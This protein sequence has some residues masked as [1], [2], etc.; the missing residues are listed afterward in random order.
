MMLWLMVSSVAIAGWTPS[1]EAKPIARSTGDEPSKQAK[2]AGKKTAEKEKSAPAPA[3]KADD[4][5]K[6]EVGVVPI[7]ISAPHGGRFAIAD[8]PLRTGPGQ[9]RAPGKFVTATDT[10]TDRLALAIA[11]A[12]EKKLGKPHLVLA[13]FQRK[14]LDVNRPVSLGAEH[15][16][17]QDLHAKYYAHLDA[18]CKAVQQKFGR[19]LLLDIHG[20]SSVADTVFRGTNHGKTVTLL[21]QRF[22]EKAHNGPESFFGLLEKM[23]VKG[24]TE[25]NGKERAGFTGGFIVQTFGSHQAN[26]IDAI[27]LEFGSNYR[28]RDAIEQVASQI[29]DAIADYHQ[30]YLVDATKKQTPAT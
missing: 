22:G 21:K 29:A 2:P 8:V 11:A 18:A 12:V 23:G 16:I 25:K 9:D 19:G 27:Q 26:G 28:K 24:Y 10:N 20:Q 5:I 1:Q 13:E 15:Q 3:K 17:S 14:Y 30:R 6:V 4:L 7:V